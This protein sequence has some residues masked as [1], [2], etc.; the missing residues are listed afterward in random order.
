[1]SAKSSL[2]HLGKRPQNKQKELGKNSLG[3]KKREMGD[4]WL[5]IKVQVKPRRNKTKKAPMVS[6]PLPQEGYQK[7]RKKTPSLFV[8]EKKDNRTGKRNERK[9]QRRRKKERMTDFSFSP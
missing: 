2:L 3:E 7:K 5:I 8:F 4:G 1:M 9:K 6:C